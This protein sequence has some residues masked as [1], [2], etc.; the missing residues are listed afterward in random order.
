MKKPILVDLVDKYES[1]SILDLIPKENLNQQQNDFKNADT[2]IF[3]NI[4]S[5]SNE[6][7]SLFK[8]NP[9]KMTEKETNISEEPKEKSK[10]ESF[11]LNVSAPL[12]D[13][14]EAT[15][16]N[17]NPNEKKLNLNTNINEN[18][19]PAIFDNLLNKNNTCSGLND[20]SIPIDNALKDKDPKGIN[21]VVDSE[22]KTVFGNLI[23][24][25]NLCKNSPENSSNSQNSKLFPFNNS[26]EPKIQ[27]FNSS[28]DA[29]P[30]L[31]SN[32]S[33]SQNSSFLNKNSIF[34]NFNNNASSENKNSLFGIPNTKVDLPNALGD[35]STLFNN[36]NKTEIGGLF[37]NVGQNLFSSNNSSNNNGN[38][39]FPSNITFGGTGLFSNLKATPTTGLFGGVSMSSDQ[40]I[41]V[42]K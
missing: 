22:K 30:S 14:K 40:D 11:K 24:S 1:K 17:A 19:K 3:N 23:G 12:K 28:S 34:N 8:L 5:S 35:K 42:K 25:S 21:K 33:D 9:I 26:V 36:N 4:K 18:I 20:N 13:V 31:F 41:T 7:N 2:F 16:T 37:K 32:P 27:P 38:S 15:I 29:N 10:D 6:Q 39:I